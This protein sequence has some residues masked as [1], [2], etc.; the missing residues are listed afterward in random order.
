MIHRALMIFMKYHSWGHRESTVLYQNSLTLYKYVSK[1]IQSEF[2]T[3]IVQ[4]FRNMSQTWRHFRFL[5]ISLL[6]DSNLDD[7]RRF[8]N[9]FWWIWLNPW[10]QIPKWYTHIYTYFSKK[11]PTLIVRTFPYV[12]C[13]EYPLPPW[14]WSYAWF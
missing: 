7:N 8:W 5:I 6:F 3:K 1:F 11:I 10:V 2:C 12:L 9:D 14:A 4:S 13:R